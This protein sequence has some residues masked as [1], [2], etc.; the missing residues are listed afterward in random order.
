MEN[1]AVIYGGRSSEHDISIITAIGVMGALDKSKYN[2]I[3]VY[4]NRDG[5]WVMPNNHLSIGSYIKRVK[6]KKL[7]VG[8]YDGCILKKRVI[9][10]KKYKKIN[11]AINCCHGMNGE[12]GSLAGLIKLAGIP[13]VG[14]GV[15]PSSVGMDKAIMKD[16]FCKNNIPCPKYLYFTE[17]E[18]LNN[19]DYIIKKIEEQI[20]YPAIIKPA[21]LGSSIGINISKNR[22]ELNKNIQIAW[23]FDKNIV[24]ERV[25]Q[26]LREINCSVIGN[27][28]NCEAS[29]LEEPKNWKSFLDFDEKYI[30]SGKNKKQVDVHIGQEMDDKIKELSKQCYKQL[31]C[32][33]VVR[34]DFLLDDKAKEVYVNE[35]NTIPGS[36]ANYLWKHKYTYTML[37]DRLIIFAK[38]EFEYMN[39]CSYSFKS[40]VLQKYG[41]GKNYSKIKSW[42][43]NYKNCVI[44]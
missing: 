39:E 26:N 22:K 10:F 16:V 14:S 7:A 18:F 17:L 27:Y 38:Q 33:G 40:N 2:V 20:S 4:I 35:I 37:L 43:K 19:K 1:V 44:I 13:M 30:L 41:G 9:G 11:V 29:I 24:V 28:K 5:L 3:P 31:G 42:L 23:N 6:G 15:L 12:D 36:Y 8:F 21:N 25:V 34:I 32:S